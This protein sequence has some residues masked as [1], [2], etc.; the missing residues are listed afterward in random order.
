M[1]KVTNFRN[2]VNITEFD[3]DIDHKRPILSFG[4]CFSNQ[5][6]KLLISNGFGAIYPYGTI[7]NPVTI[8]NNINRM[9]NNQRFNESDLTLHNKEIYF[10]WF[11]SGKIFDI[12]L[13]SLLE[14]INKEQDFV[15]D[16]LLSKPLVIVTL[17]S[18][19]VF[20]LK[21]S[22]TIVA[23]CH[24]Q[25]LDFFN[26]YR[27]SVKDVVD[28]WSPIIKDL[29]ADFIFTVSPVR[30]YRSGIIENNR[31]KSVLL[32]AVDELCKLYPK[33]TNYFPSYEIMMDELRD[34][35][36]YEKDWVHPS[37]E[38]VSYIW[39]KFSKSL[40]SDSVLKLINDV[41]SLRTRL[42]HKPNFGITS[43]YIK[44]LEILKNDIYKIK[45]KTPLYNWDKEI[46]SIETLIK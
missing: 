12:N 8:A 5:M 29:D 42:N 35:R 19:I 11:H 30:H 27:L 15:L 20:S 14:K 33:K 3:I 21:K 41:S 44:F 23:N 26:K 16:R 31:S 17:G 22:K 7:Y 6:H 24:K 38:A 34:Y 10:S 36:F 28:A 39:G 18:S 25:H 45:D 4:S 43:D 46:E 32:L 37:E 2:E 13:Q 1:N 40:F 9:L